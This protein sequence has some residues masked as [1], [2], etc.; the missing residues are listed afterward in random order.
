MK[1]DITICSMLNLK[2]VSISFGEENLCANLKQ[3]NF[4]VIKISG[5]EV[6]VGVVVDFEFCQIIV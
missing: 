1:L 2:L 5:I 4:R 3:N 6:V